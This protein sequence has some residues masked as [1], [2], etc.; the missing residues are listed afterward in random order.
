[1]RTALNDM[2]END[3][4]GKICK[5]MNNNDPEQKKHQGNFE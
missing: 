4:K 1:M 2:S 5:Q 3:G